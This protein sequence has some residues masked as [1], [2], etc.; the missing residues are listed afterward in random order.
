MKKPIA[1]EFLLVIDTETTGVNLTSEE[2]AFMRQAEMIELA[3]LPVTLIYGEHELG[4]KFMTRNGKRV[5]F[6]SLVH[7]PQ[8]KWSAGAESIHGITYDEVADAPSLSQVLNSFTL[9]VE[10]LQQAH[11]GKSPKLASYTL[12]DVQLLVRDYNRFMTVGPMPLNP[13]QA[14]DLQAFIQTIGLLPGV[15]IPRRLTLQ[16]Y[17]NYCN[18]KEPQV[19]RA[20]D[21]VLSTLEVMRCLYNKAMAGRFRNMTMF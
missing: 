14:V 16:A 19:H 8:E 21:D 17:M 12:F 9:F 20:M 5:A 6:H 4:M 18:L 7:V 11:G 3:A 2:G 10:E 13:K 1:K 15:A